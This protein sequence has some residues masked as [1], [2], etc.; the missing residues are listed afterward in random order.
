MQSEGTLDSC[1]RIAIEVAE[2]KLAVFKYESTVSTR[3]F[4]FDN[5]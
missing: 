2:H 5:L 3:L 1:E 4:I